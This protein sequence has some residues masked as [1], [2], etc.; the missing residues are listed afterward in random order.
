MNNLLI[1]LNEI[2]S[3]NCET[4]SINKIIKIKKET[5]NEKIPYIR[6]IKNGVN[7][8]DIINYETQ[9][10]L[11]HTKKEHIVNNINLI[12]KSNHDRTLF[13]KK[14]SNIPLEFYINLKNKV[15][16]ITNDYLNNDT[17]KVIAVDGTN[18]NNINQKVMLNMGYYNISDK[19]CIDLSYNGTNNRN[20]EVKCAIEEIKNNIDFFRGNIIVADRFYFCYE[21]LDFLDSNNINFIIRAKG[22]ANNLNTDIQLKKYIGNKKIIE[23]LR[24]KVKIIKYTDNIKKTV[25]SRKTKNNNSNKYK[26]T[27]ENNCVLI[28]N[29]NN[30]DKEEILELYRNRWDIETFFKII[31]NN[32][33][34]QHTKEKYDIQ[35]K[36]IYEIVMIIMYLVN[37]IEKHYFSNH[38]KIKKIKQNGK[39]INC[40]YKINKSSLINMICDYNIIN[41]LLN[42]KLNIDDITNIENNLKIVKNELNRTFPRISNIPFTKW[43]I[44]SYSNSA[45]IIK[46]L[47]HILNKTENELD[48]NLKIIASKI[49]NIICELIE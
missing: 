40:S 36:K 45:Q 44:K 39:K 10:S 33:K 19:T 20:K 18:T 8:K 15:R 2:F 46:I 7:I 29:L 26:F 1:E 37:I 48:K 49:K 9:Y 28:T 4:K 27:I 32:F 13:Y 16:N 21:F 43:N 12:N 5:S 25:Y 14:E 23:R 3:N 38:K 41:K 17:I 24:D 6:N 30:Y 11:I 42:G 35:V 31:K 34:I 47:K 22:D